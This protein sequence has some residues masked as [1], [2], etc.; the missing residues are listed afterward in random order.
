MRDGKWKLHR[1]RRGAEPYDLAQDPSESHNVADHRPNVLARLESK[2]NGWV[3][4][5][6]ENNQKTGGKRVKKLKVRSD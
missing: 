3:A 6:P 5:L 2:L 1:T 4:E